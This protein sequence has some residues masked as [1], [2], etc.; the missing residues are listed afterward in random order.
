MSSFQPL[1]DQLTVTWTSVPTATS[2]NVSINA[3]TPISLPANANTY[4]YYLYTF[5]GLTNNTVYTVSMVAINCAASSSPATMTG[6]TGATFCAPVGHAYPE[7]ELKTSG[8]RSPMDSVIANTS[9][10]T[11]P[12]QL[13]GGISCPT[14]ICPNTAVNYT[15]NVGSFAGNTLW[16]VPSVGVCSGS[17]LT[18]AQGPPGPGLSCLIS[19]SSGTCGPFT[20]TNTPPLTSNVYCLTSTLSVVVTSAMNGLVVS[21]SN[22][23]TSSGTTTP[24]GNA[25]IT[26][27]APPSVP[28]ITSLISTY[29]DQ[30]TVTWTSVPTATSYS[31]SINDSV[32]TLVPI[33]ST[34][35]PQYTFTGLTN[36][37]VYTVSVVA[38]NCAPGSSSPA[39][40]TGRTGIT[41]LVGVVL[42]MVADTH[43]IMEAVECKA[44]IADWQD[45]KPG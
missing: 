13:T 15:C 42:P 34:G 35:A 12:C 40:M 14:M 11:L 20:V 29:S 18:L 1:A 36:N 3:S 37:T 9:S 2:Y 25:S 32:N 44:M 45:R 23:T 5:T 28:T 19:Y 22:F 39:T 7:L 41:C 31:V 17:T 10:L 24:V 8:T 4:M 26:G 27:V 33:P 30:L 21:C 43:C 16:N 38:I 6:R